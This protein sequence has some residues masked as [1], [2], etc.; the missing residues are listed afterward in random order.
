[1]TRPYSCG[2]LGNGIAP[3]HDDDDIDDDGQDHF[4]DN[5]GDGDDRP[6]KFNVFWHKFKI[7]QLSK[8]ILES[9]LD[10]KEMSVVVLSQELCYGEVVYETFEHWEGGIKR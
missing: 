9:M 4:D 5:C 6:M 3:S 7:G 10:Y 8:L 1:M 2:Q